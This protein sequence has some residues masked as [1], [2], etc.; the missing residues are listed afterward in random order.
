MFAIIK[1][2]GKQIKVQPGDEIY[3]E[4]VSV[5]EGQKITFNEVL[6]T[7]TAIGTPLVKDVVVMGTIVK[8]GKGKKLRVVRYHPK[9][10]VNKVYGHRQPFTK[11]KIDDISVG[12]KVSKSIEA[13]PSTNTTEKASSTK[14]VASTAKT[15]ATTKTSTTKAAASTTKTS[16]TKAAASTSKT[17]TPK[18]AAS[19]TKT[20]SAETKTKN[21]E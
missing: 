2:G 14:A 17:S 16:T 7:D 11:V 5:E 13:K 10:N 21:E 1:T 15:A 18:A 3:I 20:K 12:G 9:K 6:A 4:K 19:T 8:Q